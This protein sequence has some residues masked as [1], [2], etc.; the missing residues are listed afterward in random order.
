[1]R[2]SKNYTID[3]QSDSLSRND[4]WEGKLKEKLNKEAVQVVKKE[5][6]LFDQISSIVNGSKSKF[7]SVDDIVKDM[8]ERSGFSRIKKAEENIDRKNPK[9]FQKYHGN[10]FKGA[11]DKLISNSGGNLSIAQVLFQLKSDNPSITDDL[12]S[13]KELIFYIKDKN[14][15]IKKNHDDKFIGGLSNVNVT[16]KEESDLFRGFGKM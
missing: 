5:E 9:I 1:M 3:R 14:E 12:F 11:V 16:D 8:Q 7:S 15:S 4:Y 10:D 13:D 6:S 2:A